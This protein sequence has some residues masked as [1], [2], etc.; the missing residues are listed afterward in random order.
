MVEETRSCSW[1][2]IMTV[3][4]REGMVEVE[5]DRRLRELKWDYEGES[6][7]H[8]WRI[9]NNAMRTRVLLWL[10][11]GSVITNYRIVLSWGNLNFAEAEGRNDT[12]LYGNRVLYFHILWM[13]FKQ[14]VITLGGSVFC[15]DYT[16]LQVTNWLVQYLRFQQLDFIDTLREYDQCV[17]KLN[18]IP[19]QS[20]FIQKDLIAF[21]VQLVW[22]GGQIFAF[23]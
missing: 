12:W 19:R 11:L 5:M 20:L 16:Y 2:M 23:C 10:W 17:T 21:C 9:W 14:I 18:L 13:A 4:R 22:N 3:G 15:V 6:G 8:G 1:M 7:D